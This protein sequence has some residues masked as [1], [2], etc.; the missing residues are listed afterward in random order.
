MNNKIDRLILK[1]IEN[2]ISDKESEILKTWLKS[3]E[4]LAYFN[5]FI[6]INYLINSKNKF[7]H[8]PSLANIKASYVN[9]NDTSKSS[10]PNKITRLYKYAAAALVLIS[11]GYFFLTKK[12]VV[13]ENNSIVKNNISIGTDKATLTLDDGSEIVLEKEQEYIG[14]NVKSNG[15]ELIYD[16]SPITKNPK[17]AYNY[18]TIP[19]G[20]QYYV[21]LSDGT[22]VWLNSESKL[23][24]PVHFDKE[25]TRIVELIYGEAFFDVTPSTSNNNTSFKV[26]SNKQDIE[27]LGTEFNVRAY[28]DE[29]F[30]Y[31]TLVEGSVVVGNATNRETLTPSRQ[32]VLNIESNEIHTTEAD[33]YSI[34]GWVKGEFRFSKQTLEDMMKTL[35]RWYDVDVV[36]KNSDTKNLVFSGILNRSNKIDV[37]L[38]KIQ[39]TGEVKFSITNKTITIE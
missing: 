28:N 3:E 24:Y 27:V 30:S 10:K 33:V 2:T 26:L 31:T 15:K 5:E 38:N 17:T 7:D 9:N 19:K 18:L 1:L 39:K 21:K 16:T 34:I 11:M 36:F 8:K 23:K 13:N 6:E 22:Q 14:N 12:H 25:E 35:S 20:G 4:N 37:L 32:A 29:A